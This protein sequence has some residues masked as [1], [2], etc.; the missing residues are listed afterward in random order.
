MS[1][2]T[3][4]KRDLFIECCCLGSPSQPHHSSARGRV[5]ESDELWQAGFHPSFERERV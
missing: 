2:V 3:E 1:K 5:C 4:S